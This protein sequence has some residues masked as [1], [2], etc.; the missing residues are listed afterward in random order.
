MAA[1]LHFRSDLAL[2]KVEV[3][4]TDVSTYKLMLEDFTVLVTP[5]HIFHDDVHSLQDPRAPRCIRIQT[6]RHSLCEYGEKIAVNIRLKNLR[7]MRIKEVI[8]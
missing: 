4:T 1:V 3:F 6:K 5:L 8:F 2:V 7:E